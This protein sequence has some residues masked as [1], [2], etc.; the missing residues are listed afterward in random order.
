MNLSR[1][2]IAG[3]ALAA[4]AVALFLV[5][6]FVLGAAGMQQAPR[7]FASL[8]VPPAIVFGVVAL[9]VLARRSDSGGEG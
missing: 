4:L 7:L 8:C 2:L 3:T 9:F 6:W 1:T 5:L